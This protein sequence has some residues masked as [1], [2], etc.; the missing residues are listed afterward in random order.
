MQ[1][2]NK[3]RIGISC[4][5][6]N[7]FAFL[8][9]MREKERGGERKLEREKASDNA[10]IMITEIKISSRR[11]FSLRLCMRKKN[12][13]NIRN[14]NRTISFFLYNN[15]SNILKS[16]FILHKSNVTVEEMCDH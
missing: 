7:V 5:S 13:R 9:S 1:I 3:C 14:G 10:S 11:D 6:I 16:F 12:L 2:M 4:G 8:N 15:N